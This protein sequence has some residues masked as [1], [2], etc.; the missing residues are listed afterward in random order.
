MSGEKLVKGFLV[1]K[2]DVKGKITYCNSAFIEISGFNESELLGKPHSIVRH[3]DMPRS[4]FAYLWENITQGKEVNVYVK[5]RAKD[6]GFYWVFAN[7]TPSFNVK[8]E[9]IGY[10]S[11]RR[12]PRQEGIKTATE[13]YA[14]IRESEKKGGVKEGLNT[15][16]TYFENLKMPYEDYVMHLQTGE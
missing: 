10:Y 7:V 4:I 16:K 9:I 12:E 5:N 13:L 8:G 3:P 6:G 15:F 2:T 1:S 14:L 11:V